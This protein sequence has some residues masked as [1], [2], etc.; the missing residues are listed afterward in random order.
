[1]RLAALPREWLDNLAQA[2]TVGK[3]KAAQKVVDQIGAS[4][5]LL[6]K[7]M[8]QMV[9]NLQVDELLELIEK[10]LG[11]RTQSMF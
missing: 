3:Y 7:Q 5:E 11:D 1:M 8:R 4:D 9:K 2:I 10:A 6:A